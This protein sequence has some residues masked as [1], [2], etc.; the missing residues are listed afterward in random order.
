MTK[1][2][3]KSIKFGILGAFI[4]YDFGAIFPYVISTNKMPLYLQLLLIAIH[5]IVYWCLIKKNIKSIKKLIHN[6]CR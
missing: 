6:F 2:I 4:L 1:D 3:I 5:V